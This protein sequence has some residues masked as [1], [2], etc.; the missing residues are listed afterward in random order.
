VTAAVAGSARV[1][2]RI[3][4]RFRLARNEHAQKYEEKPCSNER[5]DCRR[6]KIGRFF[7][8]AFADRH[9]VRERWRH[10]RVRTCAEGAVECAAMACQVAIEGLD[11]HAG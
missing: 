10:G 1:A 2:A 8:C 4:R 9:G 6:H 11:I 7:L 3:R 5:G